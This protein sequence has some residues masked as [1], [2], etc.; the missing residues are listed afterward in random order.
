VQTGF[1]TAFGFLFGV[2][3]AGSLLQGSANVRVSYEHLQIFG[4]AIML[5]GAAFFSVPYWAIH[6]H[7]R[8]TDS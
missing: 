5:G 7:N 2:P 8:A 6:K 1:S 4:G 3:I